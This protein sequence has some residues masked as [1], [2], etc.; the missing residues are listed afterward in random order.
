MPVLLSHP[1]NPE[2]SCMEVSGFRHD[3]IS[4]LTVIRKHVL[5]DLT[6]YVC[7]F[8]QCAKAETMF[9]SRSEWYTHELQFH[10]RE[11][12]C[13]E[14]GHKVHSSQSAFESHLRQYHDN[15]LSEA[16]LP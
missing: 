15:G 13:G 10:R 2:Y 1:R 14:Q 8:E 16:Q 5:T 9:E 4:M 7:T 3:V 6:P 11:W 12:V